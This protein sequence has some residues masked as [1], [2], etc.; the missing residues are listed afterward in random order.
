MT[1]KA[2]QRI[3]AVEMWFYRRILRIPKTAHQTNEKVLQKMNQKWKLL[4]C[5]EKR[6]LEFFRHVICKEKL[7][8]LVLSG[9][10]PGKRG[11][12]SQRYT[13]IKNFKQNFQ[14]SKWI[15]GS[16]TKPSFMAHQRSTSRAETAMIRKEECL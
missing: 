11:R 8:N 10:L 9:R 14:S 4:R 12:G 16:C 6:Q 13:F 15:M 7:E 2:K 5:V 3:E 1:T